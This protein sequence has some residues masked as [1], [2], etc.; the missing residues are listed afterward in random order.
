[1]REKGLKN[2]DLL[3]GGLL[4]QVYL[5][6]G[7]VW[8]LYNM[9]NDLCNYFYRYYIRIFKKFKF[10]VFVFENVFGIFFVGDGKFF[11]IVQCY[12]KKVGYEIEYCILNS[13]DF[14]VL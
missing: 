3:I 1:M 5:F 8:D 2:I 12:F 11:L 10:E 13:V 7:R 6:V 4:C 14:F 9:E